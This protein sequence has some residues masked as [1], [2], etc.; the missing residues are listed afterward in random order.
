MS[1]FQRARYPLEFKL[2]AVRLTRSGQSIA[3]VAKTLGIA[4]QTLH[5][6]IK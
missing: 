1:K 4:E 5:N 6:P 3:A 2:E